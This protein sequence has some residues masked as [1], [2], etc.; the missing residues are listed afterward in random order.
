MGKK[1]RRPFF[2]A[3]PNP[4]N[5]SLGAA[6]PVT[7]IRPRTRPS[8]PSGEAS[9]TMERRAAAIAAAEAECRA[10]G[11]RPYQEEATV[12]WKSPETREAWPAI[13][14]LRDAVTLDDDDQEKLWTSI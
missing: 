14:A 4:S 2:F 13:A 8:R 3:V 1:S 7:L 10:A 11:S 12:N 6:T 5:N 9:T